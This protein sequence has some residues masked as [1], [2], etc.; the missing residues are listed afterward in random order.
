MDREDKTSF[1]ENFIT[2]LMDTDP[3]T[4]MTWMSKLDMATFENEEAGWHFQTEDKSD[5]VLINEMA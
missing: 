2:S 3:H 4:W 1:S 5:K